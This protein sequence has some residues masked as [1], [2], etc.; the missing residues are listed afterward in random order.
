[1][2]GGGKK[3]RDFIEEFVLL[4]EGGD[5]VLSTMIRAYIASQDL[6]MPLY[7]GGILDQPALATKVYTMIASALQANRQK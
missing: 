3:L 2:V 6:S 7:E 5:R 1:M 4:G